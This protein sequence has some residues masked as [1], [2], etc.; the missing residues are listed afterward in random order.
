[1][2]KELY[3]QHI[4]DVALQRVFHDF[5][6]SQMCFAAQRLKKPQKKKL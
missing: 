1:M 5:I 3:H 6:L 4:K 2:V